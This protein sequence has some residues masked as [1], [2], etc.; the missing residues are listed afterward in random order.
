[1]SGALLARRQRTPAAT[2]RA[3]A[4]ERLRVSLAFPCPPNLQTKL[5]T[6]SAAAL[7]AHKLLRIA[8]ANGA[9]SLGLDER[10]EAAAPVGRI[11]AQHAADFVSVKLSARELAG[12]AADELADA[13]V[14]GCGNAQLC[15][16]I[17]GG[18]ERWPAA[19]TSGDEKG[20]A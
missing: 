6:R 18:V 4:C 10:D 7:D 14:F 19:Q 5:N 12:V 9:R 3:R 1:M 13:L 16:T 17:V 2:A 11:A 8:T 15:R 20:G